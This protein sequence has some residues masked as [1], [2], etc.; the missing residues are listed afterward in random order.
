MVRVT[1]STVLQLAENDAA[2]VLKEDGTLEASMPEINSENVPENVLTGA[3]I[4]YALNN[5]DIC[6]L[7]FKNFAEQCKNNS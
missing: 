7:I 2:I 6:Q 1:R 3:A 5:P 4:L